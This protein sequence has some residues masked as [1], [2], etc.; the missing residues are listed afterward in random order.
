MRR[1][2]LIAVIGYIL[3]IIWGIYYE[4]IFP[5]WLSIIAIYYLI[6]KFIFS[7][8]KFKILAIKRYLRYIK[9]YLNKISLILII[10]M[11]VISN[12]IVNQNNHIYER[13]YNYKDNIEIIAIVMSDKV[14]NEYNNTY[15]IKI[16]KTDI[17]L[18]AYINKN[19]NIEYGDKIHVKGTYLKPEIQRNYKGF[20]YSKYL[21]SK[22]IYGTVKSSYV[23][24]ISKDNINPL[25][26]YCKK[27]SKYIKNKISGN[28]SNETKN[29]LLGLLLG[30][31]KNIDD[32]TI[33]KFRTSSISHI[34]AISGMHISYIIIGV[35]IVLKKTIGYRKSKY[36]TILIIVFYACLIGFSPSI[37]RASLMGVLSI[38]ASILYRKSDTL[39]NIAFS[40]LIL[41]IYN[42][43][44]I[45]D[46]GFQFSYAGTLSIVLFNKTTFNLLKCIKNKYKQSIFDNKLGKGIS[47]II[48]AQIL[49]FIISLIHY[50]TLGVYFIITNL[51][52]SII[53]GPIIIIGIIYII[54]LIINI[55]IASFIAII[56]NFLIKILLLISN[57]SSLP[58]SKVYIATP[59][60]TGICIYIIFILFIQSLYYIYKSPKNNQTKTR[61]RNTI[62]LL[63]FK[64]KSKKKT[65]K[66]LMVFFIMIYIIYVIIP[67]GLKIHFV[68]VG[69]G[70]CTFII[71]PGN[72]TILIDGGGK[73]NSTFDVGK[74]VLLPY[75]LNRGYTKIDYIFISHFD[76]D[77]SLGCVKII[78]NINVSSII[79]SEQF[80]ENDIY[81][82]I[83]AMAKEK[84]IK[85]IYV[86]AGNVLNIDGMK[87]TILHPQN[88]L[89]INNAV[90]NNS[91]VCKIEYQSF[92]MLFTGDIEQEAEGLMLNKNIKLKADILKVAHHRFKNI[93]Y[94]RIFKSCF[95]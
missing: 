3:G 2:I 37:V 75:I 30:D 62:A 50:S 88:E 67:K 60:F 15:K 24:L 81:K 28:M 42:P 40:A 8:K 31:I 56:L 74:S 29:I 59:N 49:T 80:E 1:P 87:L 89:M 52:T 12:I 26:K 93:H 79:L 85:L 76:Y 55:K 94:F 7:K 57:F 27:L 36:I 64:I 9:L 66:I 90:N 73:I 53:I 21:K 92:S 20:D 95:S 65:I 13:I 32:N 25:L 14:E 54:I 23:K 72:K 63:K 34:L 33:E 47:V 83:V 5:F 70:D 45:Y 78:E 58:L 43:F 91:I 39:T 19:I 69:Q 46:L 71:T 61:F 18:Y 84:N 51:L 38:I 22:K 82:Q 48:S 68:D 6:K 16:E 35:S 77:H 86:K 4:S 10:L 41:L 44:I 11:S 17:Y